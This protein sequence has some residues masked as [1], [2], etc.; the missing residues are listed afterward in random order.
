MFF[1]FSAG[2]VCS[3]KLTNTPSHTTRHIRLSQA[4]TIYRDENEEITINAKSLFPDHTLVNSARL[5]FRFFWLGFPTHCF[6][7]HVPRVLDRS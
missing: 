1:H 4:S 3:P 6:S 5:L 7:S 2:S